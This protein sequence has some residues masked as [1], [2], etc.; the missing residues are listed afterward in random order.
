[1]SVS[2]CLCVCVSVSVN[3]VHACA[4]AQKELVDTEDRGCQTEAMEEPE[5]DEPDGGPVV[6]KV[7]KMKFKKASPWP[8]TNCLRAVQSI[9]NDKI[10]ADAVD[11]AQNNDR[12]NMQEYVEDW[13]QVH[14]VFLLSVRL[15]YPIHSFLLP[16]THRTNT[17]PGPCTWRRKQSL[18]PR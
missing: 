11:D 9:Y 16:D 12:Q 8:L 7:K 15:S 10:K 1:M 18:Q 14:R 4:T 2:V 3:V 5:D 6:K 13:F 17:A